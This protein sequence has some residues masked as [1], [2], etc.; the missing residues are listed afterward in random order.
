MNEGIPKDINLPKAGLVW[1]GLSAH[2]KH[3]HMYGFMVKHPS[4]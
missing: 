3:S 1:I 4:F 2:I